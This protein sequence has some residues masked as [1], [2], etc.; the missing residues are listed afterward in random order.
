[1][2]FTKYYGKISNSGSDERG[3]YTGGRPG[4]QT[5]REWAIIPW[6]SRPWTHVLRYPNPTAARQI[7]SLAIA[8]AS[9]D[10]IGYNQDTRYTYWELLQKA[11]YNP[12]AISVP[13]AADCSAGVIANTKAAG[14][15]LGIAALANLG[16]SYTGDMVRGFRAAGFQVITDPS[17]LNSFEKLQPGDILLYEGHHTATYIGE[18]PSNSRPAP[19]P[20]ASAPKAAPRAGSLNETEQWVGEVT[21]DILNVRTWAGPN[22]PNLQSYPQLAQGNLVS[23]LDSVRGD[24][25]ETWLFIS[26]G[27]QKRKGFV[28]AKYIKRR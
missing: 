10:N 7:A 15:L 24:D 20:P 14:H 9:N 17:Y 26:I 5:G 13:C 2:D 16:A 19:T 18:N 28:A 3:R 12:S 23:V 22:Y 11:N 21:A 8:A 6:Y 4:D 1:M 25:G 27:A